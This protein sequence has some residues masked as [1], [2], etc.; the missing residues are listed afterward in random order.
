[1][2][3]VT[4]GPDITPHIDNELDHTC[5]DTPSFIGHFR[6]STS[7][8]QKFLYTNAF[9]MFQHRAVKRLF[10]AHHLLAIF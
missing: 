1:M 8:A 3:T 7:P 5:T 2:S 9:N 4:A 10:N 6:A